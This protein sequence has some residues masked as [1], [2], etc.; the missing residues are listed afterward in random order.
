MTVRASYAQQLGTIVAVQGNQLQLDGVGAFPLGEGVAAVGSDGNPLHILGTVG[1]AAILR[2]NPESNEVWGIFSQRRGNLEP[3]ATPDPIIAGFFVMRYD[4]PLTTDDILSLRLLASAGGNASVNL[5]WRG[6][7]ITLE[8]TAPGVYTA[9]YVIPDEMEIA[10]TRLIARLVMPTGRSTQAQS[11][12]EVMV[13]TLPPRIYNTTPP[14][15]SVVEPVQP[16]ITANFQDRGPSG[17]DPAS[18][19]IRLDGRDASPRAQV[20]ATGLVRIPERL[21]PGN[22][23]VSIEVSDRAGNTAVETW[24]FQVGA[25]GPQILGVAHDAAEP[26]QAGD[27]ITVTARVAAP[28]RRAVFDIGD[29]VQGVAMQLQ[30]DT[31]TYTGTYTVREADRAENAPVVVH[32]TDA[33]GVVHDATADVAV[34]IVPPQEAAEFAITTPQD[35][36]RTARRIIPAG[37]GPAG[38]RVRWIIT[39][40]KLILGGEVA[41]GEVTVGDDGTWQAAE[42]IDLKLPLLGMADGYVLTAQL[43]GEDGAV[44]DEQ[45]VEFTAAE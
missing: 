31:N 6:T 21:A 15:E 45:E 22:H 38:S 2:L 7:V 20:T 4:G 18:V 40:R 11:N 44:V 8:E 24:S 26:L 25:A 14:P 32:F 42:E 17:I 16:R 23:T 43:L 5:P 13:D 28:G 10:G 41:R 37:T 12:V 27:T 29:V 9:D 1:D 33:G 30:A 3:P 19:A 36:Q 39:Y 34:T 35:G